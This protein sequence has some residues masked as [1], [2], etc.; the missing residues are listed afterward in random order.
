[1]KKHKD[2]CRCNKCQ[3]AREHMT[4]IVILSAIGIY[5]VLAGFLLSI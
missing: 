5:I 1:M 3:D 4:N 2:N